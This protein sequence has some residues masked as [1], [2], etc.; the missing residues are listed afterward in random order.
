MAESSSLGILGQLHHVP[1][2]GHASCIPSILRAACARFFS[3]GVISFDYIVESS[4]LVILGELH[5]TK[6]L[7]VH[8]LSIQKAIMRLVSGLVH[9]MYEQVTSLAAPRLGIWS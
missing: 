6:E 5:H 9:M 4:P 2:V 1:S 8:L 3:F 7:F